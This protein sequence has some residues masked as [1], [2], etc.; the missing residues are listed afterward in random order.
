M[1]SCAHCASRG[2]NKHEQQWNAHSYRQQ[3]NMFHSM[4]IIAERGWEC[5]RCPPFLK[6]RY[7]NE[8]P[9]RNFSEIR[10]PKLE[11]RNKWG[12]PAETGRKSCEKPCMLQNE[13]RRSATVRGGIAGR[14]SPVSLAFSLFSLLSFVCFGFRVSCFEFPEIPINPCIGISECIHAICAAVQT[15]PL[16]SICRVRKPLLCKRL[17]SIGKWCRH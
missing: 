15:P 12:N 16:Q 8:P 5:K 2:H 14:I 7:K 13:A 11:I 10:N 9:C 17:E 6:F 3:F 4:H 1:V